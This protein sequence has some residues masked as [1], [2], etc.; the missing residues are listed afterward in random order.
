[1]AKG[2]TGLSGL[3]GFDLTLALPPTMNLGPAHLG[4][5][6]A[7]PGARRARTR[8]RFEVQEFRRP[9]FEVK[10]TASEGPHLVGGHATAT[11]SAAYYAGGA[12]PG[13]EVSWRV[14]ATPGTFRPP[15]WEDFVFGTF[16]PWW[17]PWPEPPEP[18]RVETYAGADR[19]RR[20]RT[21]CASTSTA[22]TRRGRATS[23]VEATVEDVNRQAWT[24]E[25]DLLV[26]PADALRGAARRAGLRG[27]GRGDPGRRRSSPTSTGG[28]T[29]GRTVRLRAERLDWKQV[30]GE[31]RLVPEDVQEREVESGTEPV[32]VQL[33]RPRGRLVARVARVSD[34]QD[35]PN[36][37]ELRVWVAGG[38][39]PP[40]RDL[41][42]EEVTLV[43][44]RKEY[45]AGDV[46]RVLVLAPF[47]PAEGL[48]TLR[49]SGLLR[50]ERFSMTGASHTLE[51]P[52][53][54]AWTPNVHVQVDLVGSA[55][56]DEALERA[57]RARPSPAAPST[58]PSRPGA[59]RL[60]G[61]G[62]APR[63]GLAPGGET[64]LDLAL[65]DADG[66]PVPGGEVAVVVV[67][68]AVLALTGYRL[69]DPLDVFYA[70]RGAGRERPPPPQPRPAGRRRTTSPS[71]TEEPSEGGA[72][73]GA[74]R[75][76]AHGRRRAATPP[77]PMARSG[78]ADFEAEARPEPIRDAHR[79]L[80]PRPLRPE[81][82]HRRRRA[83]PRSR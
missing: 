65:R 69:P 22:G 55:P 43:P 39:V 14:A 79:L 36:E 3:G 25:V 63:A 21:A 19:R 54:E 56:R 82:R 41:E 33:R 47:A 70:R 44:D 73:G 30:E 71:V 18:E 80:G 42:Q 23:A 38:R 46:A 35:R 49:R 48:L 77:A 13:A 20:R 76:V 16:V 7:A 26:H 78:M 15:H 64:V 67:D 29:P 37:T 2:T 1:M 11:V 66:R 34:E 12:L 17:E 24:A 31:W 27:E 5:E 9:E 62:D 53:E 75:A 81:R 72:L 51:I 52:I 28:A 58:S 59:R 8:T 4:L 40:R 32:R 74:L 10:A 60:G 50:E 45:G 57:P 83:G 6:A 68:E 61:R